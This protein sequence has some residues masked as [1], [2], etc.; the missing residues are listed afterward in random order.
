MEGETA[1]V[2][3]L[4]KAEADLNLQNKVCTLV[5]ERLCVHVHVPVVSTPQDGD[6]A[7]IQATLRHRSDALR[8]LV[9]AG[10]DLNLQNQVRYLVT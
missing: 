1:V 9:S 10:A 6:S 8:E 2:V 7:V 3:E 5:S 4:V